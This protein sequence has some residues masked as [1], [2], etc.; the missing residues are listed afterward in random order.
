MANY[1]PTYCERRIF[2][3]AAQPQKKYH[4]QHLADERR[5]GHRD[6]RG[7]KPVSVGRREAFSLCCAVFICFSSQFGSSRVFKGGGGGGGRREEEE[8]GGGGVCVCVCDLV[9]VRTT[10][11]GGGQL[12]PRP[13]ASL[14]AF[15]AQPR[16]KD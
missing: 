10:G 15:T 4:T 16:S 14:R 3:S 6:E 9:C 2:L 7:E 8:G 5:T 12:L 11:L 13:A 1:L